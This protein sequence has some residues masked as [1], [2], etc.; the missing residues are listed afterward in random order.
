MISALMGRLESQV[1]SEISTSSALA[2]A[3]EDRTKRSFMV[4][5]DL[6]ILPVD[7]V[8]MRSGERSGGGIFY[9]F[10]ISCDNCEKIK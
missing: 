3:S 6:R 9:Y 8:G 2:R 7:F 5:D 4:V 1:T 10:L